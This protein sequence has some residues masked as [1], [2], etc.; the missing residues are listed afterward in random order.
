MSNKIKTAFLIVRVIDTFKIKLIK[1]AKKGGQTLSEYV[2]M[3][4]EN[5]K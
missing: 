3:I 1:K 2:R 5:E 4:L